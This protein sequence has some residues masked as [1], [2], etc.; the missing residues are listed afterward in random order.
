MPSLLAI[1]RLPTRLALSRASSLPLSARAFSSSSVVT[2]RAKTLLED[3]DQGLGFIRSNPRAPKPR[4]LGLTEMRGPYYSAYGT[5]HLEDVFETMGTHVDGL[6][7]AGGS[8]AV[9]PEGRVREMIEVAHRNGVYVSTGGFIEHILTH[10]DV[11]S[12]VDR[13][14]EQCKDLGFDVVEL[15]SGFLSFPPDDWLRLVEKVQKHGLKPKP[16]LGIQF[17][18][19]GD[20]EA[21]AL[22]KTGTSDP[23]KLV[24]MGRKFLAAGVEVMMIE[25]EGIT[26]NVR[27]WR[28]DVIQKI[29]RDLPMET[30]MFEAAEPK[31]FNWYVRE[32]GVDVNLFVDH[33]Q[34]VQLACLRS[35]IWGMADTFGKVVSFRDDK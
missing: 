9:M 10:A 2:Q 24:E 16:E 28:T 23:A 34:V 15:S 33:S 5:R 11:H 4:K 27:T 18:A 35:G 6:K 26:E 25:S 29:L 13:Y 3:K 20:T 12:V 19:G 7:F 14:L 21:S 22:E 8:F 17:G 31:A 32:F 30:V 1:P